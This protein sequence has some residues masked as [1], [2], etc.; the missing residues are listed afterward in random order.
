MKES[1]PWITLLLTGRSRTKNPMLMSLLR[2]SIKELWMTLINKWEVVINQRNKNSFHPDDWI[3]L[4]H[5][6]WK[7]FTGEAEIQM[8][9]G[10]WVEGLQLALRHALFQRVG[11]LGAERRVH[12]WT[13]L[14]SYSAW[15]VQSPFEDIFPLILFYLLSYFLSFLRKDYLPFPSC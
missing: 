4:K 13:S 11:T 2:T 5:L 10:R 9:I 7:T 1:L 6:A 15:L 12:K 8:G 3:L 14:Y